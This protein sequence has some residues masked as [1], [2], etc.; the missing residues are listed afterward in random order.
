MLMRGAFVTST[1][2]GLYASDAVAGGNLRGPA[3]ATDPDRLS[4]AEL[5]E[6]PDEIG[7]LDHPGPYSEEPDMTDATKPK[8][9]SEAWLLAKANSSAAAS[10]C[11]TH[12]TGFVCNATTRVRCCK[13]QNEGGFVKCGSTAN[14]A[15]CAAQDS[16]VGDANDDAQNRSNNSLSSS[17]W[18]GGYDD[19]R[20]RWDDGRRRGGSWGGGGWHIHQGWHTS[21][22]CQSHHVGSFCASHHIVHCCNDYGHYVECNTAYT[23]S[24]RWC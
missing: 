20:R 11:S 18:S 15:F 23:D 19:R 2:V 6:M 12:G 17:W 4:I 14:S 22:Y 13:L 7:E 8:P 16:G 5:V 10:L 24:N 9:V 21:S 3:N 1:L